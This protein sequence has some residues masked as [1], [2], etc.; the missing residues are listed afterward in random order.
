MDISRTRKL[1]NQ[2]RPPHREG[3][4][5]STLQPVPKFVAPGCSL[6]K[7]GRLTDAMVP[8]KEH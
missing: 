4:P 8:H 2:D 7:E 3:D 6:A 1:I 5:A